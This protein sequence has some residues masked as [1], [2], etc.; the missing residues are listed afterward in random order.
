MLKIFYG[1][2]EDVC[3]GL[4]WFEY[5]YDLKWFQD[6]LVQQMLLD[7]DKSTY[8]KEI[9][10]IRTTGKFHFSEQIY[11]EFYPIYNAD[12]NAMMEDDNQNVVII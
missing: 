1:E 7:M 8:I 9:Y 4:L 11:H 10:G 12:T 6:K 5:S 2:M 3:Y